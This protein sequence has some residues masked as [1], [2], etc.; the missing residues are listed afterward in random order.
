MSS[1]IADRSASVNEEETPLLPVEH[2]V[3]VSATRWWMLALTA[4]MAFEQGWIWN[5]WGPIAGSVQSAFDWSNGMIALLANYGAICYL[6][7]FIPSAWVL[8]VKGLRPACLFA[9]GLMFLATS[10]RCF[11]SQQL[12]T[13]VSAHIGA[14]ING[15]AGPMVSSFPPLLS[16]TW[17]PPGQRT[18]ATAVTTLS[19]YLGVAFSFVMGP[20]LM[21]AHE[22]VPTAA[23]LNDITSS[24]LHYCWMQAG[25]ALI[26]LVCMVLHLPNKVNFSI[27]RFTQI[28]LQALVLYS[29][30][31]T[32]PTLEVCD[33]IPRSLRPGMQ[34]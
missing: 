19:Q 26:V 7:M 16:S 34:G 1:E 31:A 30:T 27:R 28:L 12:A 3:Q 5:T 6:I 10:I 9:A 8:D 33:C 15:L 21:P 20:Q 24:V 2:E 14:F 32:L 4:A 29:T 23:N 13:T 17:F 11:S 22:A 25:F 18:T